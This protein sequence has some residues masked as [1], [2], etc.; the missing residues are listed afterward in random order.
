MTGRRKLTPQQLAEEACLGVDDVERLVAA[1]VLHPDEDGLHPLENVVQIRLV[2]AL[3][4]GGIGL[5]DVTW[6]VGEERLPL[7]RIG[8]M[9]TLAESSGRTFEEFAAAL[10]DRGDLLGSIYAAFGIA[11]PAPDTVMRRDEEDVLVG[12]LEVWGMVDDRPDVYLRAARLAGEG[13]RRLELATL[14]LF[15]ELGGPPPSRLQKGLPP[16]EAMRP[17]ELIGAQMERML[18]WLHRRQTEH[19]VIERVVAGV[20]RALARAGRREQRSFEPPAIAFVDLAGYTRLAE[21]DGD[22]QA[23]R[24]ATR[25]HSLALDAARA[26]EGRVVK[27]LGDGVM[28]RFAATRA[29]V[30][31]VAALMR[32]MRAFDLP[33]AHAGI[34]TGP[35]VSRD[36]DV[37]GH[38]VNLAARIAA[39]A[40]E[41]EL[42][43]LEDY[44][45]AAAAAGF[46]CER[47][48]PVELKGIA[49]PV[50][51]ARVLAPQR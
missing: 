19:E 20:E 26:H 44:A 3:A 31:S 24:V 2:Q 8:A 33:S 49:E 40:A 51:L 25:L 47:T 50:R 7:D 12:F 34:A 43:L 15:D 41:D 29:A 28:L 11:V 10:G 18:V 45:D 1:G 16:D 32:T 22:E 5:D 9:W 17:S 37:Y 14:D 13:M 27:L 30:S 35:I 36:G 38:T 6:A 46:E 21:T 23:A 48:G 39:H 4:E 42:L